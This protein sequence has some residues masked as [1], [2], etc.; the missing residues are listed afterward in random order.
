MGHTHPTKE[1]GNNARCAHNIG[2]QITQIGK[3]KEH[4]SLENRILWWSHMLNEECKN[5]RYTYTN[6]DRAHKDQCRGPDRL[7][8]GQETQLLLS[9]FG[10]EFIQDHRDRIVQCGLTKDEHI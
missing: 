5:E 1:D 4:D 2:K 9:Q 8:K 3:H 6:N 7:D 10:E